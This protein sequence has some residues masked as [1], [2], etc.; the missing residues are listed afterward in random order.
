[1]KTFPDNPNLDHLRQQAKDLLA[2][3]R[4]ADPAATLAQAQALLAEQYG[5]GSWTDLKREVDRRQGSAEVADPALA[6]ELADRY[7]LG[8]VTGGMRSVAPVDEMGRRC[9]VTAR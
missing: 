5:F 7:G 8:A 1:M 2:G 3:L 6:R 9:V 4:D